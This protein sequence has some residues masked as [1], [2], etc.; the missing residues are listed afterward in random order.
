MYELFTDPAGGHFLRTLLGAGALFFALFLTALGLAMLFWPHLKRRMGEYWFAEALLGL[1]L[2]YLAILIMMSVML[3]TPD[4][5][6]A[7]LAGK[8]GG[9][10]GWAL[11]QMSLMYLGRL[12]TW[13]IL[14]AMLV[15]GAVSDLSV[16]AVAVADAAGRVSDMGGARPACTGA[17]P[18]AQAAA[19]GVTATAA[20]KE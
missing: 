1:L 11:A 16:H 5:F 7:A 18:C 14:I 4:P 2:A 15:G 13:A 20:E 10:V 8:G 12:P 17:I 19:T 9:M 3:K 6:V